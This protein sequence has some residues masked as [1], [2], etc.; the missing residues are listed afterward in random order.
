MMTNEWQPIETAPKVE[1]GL[2]LA[3]CS[4][5]DQIEVLARL[6]GHWWLDWLLRRNPTH[7]MPLPAPPQAPTP[8]PGTHSARVSR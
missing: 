1:G 2:I 5:F 8:D 7:W 4:D 3:Y 6:S